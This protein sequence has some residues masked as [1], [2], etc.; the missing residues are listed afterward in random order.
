MTTNKL[1]EFPKI[2]F[3]SSSF[4]FPLSIEKRGAPPIPTRLAKAIANVQIGNATPSPVK[5]SV[6]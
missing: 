1:K 6:A 4:P 2:Y 3:A 5:A